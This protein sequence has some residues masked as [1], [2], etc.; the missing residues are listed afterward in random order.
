[1]KF[2][3]VRHGQTDWNA[4]GRIQ[5]KTDIE[6]NEI[7]I[8][9]A[10]QLKALIKDYNIDLIISSPL[11]RARKTAE[12]I[13]ETVKCNIIFE[14]SLKERGYGIF[15]GMI[16]KEINDELL[17]DVVSKEINDELINSDI[18]NNYY[19]NKEYKEIETIQSLCSRVWK[20]LDNLK[21]KYKDNNILLVTHG[22]TI[23]AINGY[24]NGINEKGII[25]NPGLKNCEIKFYEC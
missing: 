7:G 5:G 9:Q 20:L 12:I 14:D 17:I 19:I 18:L 3:V 1:M 10:R 2:Y 25:D 16:R 11:K 22:G 24:F 13:N 15:E 6:L 23:R 4:K 8:E 21:P